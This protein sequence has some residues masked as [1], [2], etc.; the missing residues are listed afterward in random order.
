M[1][2]SCP[3]L[4]SQAQVTT[5][6]SAEGMLVLLQLCCGTLFLECCCHKR[7]PRHWRSCSLSNYVTGIFAAIPTGWIVIRGAR[8]A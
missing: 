4:M 1:A 7:G 8:E 5:S 6:S 3:S 2:L